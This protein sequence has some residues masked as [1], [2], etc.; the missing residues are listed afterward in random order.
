MDSGHNVTNGGEFGQNVTH[1][2]QNSSAFSM[3]ELPGGGTKACTYGKV[4]K[5]YL[6]TF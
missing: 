6:V 1:G 4:C 3:H 2:L 5:C